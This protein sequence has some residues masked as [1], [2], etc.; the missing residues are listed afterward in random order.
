MLS[1]L[2]A[3]NT[4]SAIAVIISIW[5]PLIDGDEKKCQ[6]SQNDTLHI[7]CSE[8][9]LCFHNSIVKFDVFS[10]SHEKY[11]LVLLQISLNYPGTRFLS[12]EN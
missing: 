10:G 11:F 4:L 5:K 12:T 9:Y 3:L 8:F 7:K 1:D 2:D 6:I